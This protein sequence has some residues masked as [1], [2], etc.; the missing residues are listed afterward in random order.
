MQITAF[1]KSLV[2]N[3]VQSSIYFP[4]RYEVCEIQSAQYI[5]EILQIPGTKAIKYFYVHLWLPSHVFPSQ[6]CVQREKS[7]IGKRLREY[8]NS[9]AHQCF[10]LPAK[11]SHNLHPNFPSFSW[12]A[13]QIGLSDVS[14]P[15][16]VL[17]LMRQNCCSRQLARSSNACMHAEVS[18][19]LRRTFVH[20]SIVFCGKCIAE[21]AEQMRWSFEEK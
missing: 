18:S 7:A 8:S 11:C 4:L 19:T 2:L 5:Y 15:R 12:E 6:T 10:L 3:W 13:A 17:N 1:C 14:F 20:L 9:G 21:V 16:C